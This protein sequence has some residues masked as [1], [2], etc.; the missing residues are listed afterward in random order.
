MRRRRL[1]P[2]P[3]PPPGMMFKPLSEGFISV[4]LFE[5]MIDEY[6]PIGSVPRE[7]WGDDYF[8]ADELRKK[9]TGRRP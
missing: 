2:L 5:F 1:P 3:E 4:H 9:R 7:E 8:A 6:M